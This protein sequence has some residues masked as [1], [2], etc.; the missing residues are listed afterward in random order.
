M[1]E[2]L[3][4]KPIIINTDLDGLISGLILKEY[5]DCRVIGFSNSAE[6]FWLNKQS[7]NDFKDACFVDMYVADPDT[8]VIDQHII[9]VNDEHHG[10]LSGNPNKINPNLL[11]KRCFL[12]NQSYYKKYPFGTVHF[13]VALLEGKGVDL[14]GLD[15]DRTEEGL[16]FIDLI[17]RSD[18]AM[19]TTINSNYEANANEWWDWLEGES[20][21]G[22]ITIKFKTYLAHL[23]NTNPGYAI[24][25]K[26]EIARILQNT[27]FNCNSPDGG[28]RNILE[29][30]KLKENAK[31][32]FQFISDIS[33]ITL[34]DIDANFRTYSGTIGRTSLTSIQQN[35]LISAN[36]LCGEKIFSYAFVR[37]S[38][39]GNNFSYTLKKNR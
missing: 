1:I 29:E 22:A 37:T 15:L 4:N 8:I 23:K 19:N 35:E 13:I 30:D 27:P 34:F 28:I 11:N 5:L 18:D 31:K 32:Y 9:S 26:N 10:V 38:N 17:L 36:T 39:R 14:T 20:D 21:G 7:V 2:L 16:S 12:P 25:K 6:K 3:K 24:K 33:G